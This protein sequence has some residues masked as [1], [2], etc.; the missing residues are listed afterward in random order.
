MEALIQI[1]EVIMIKRNILVVFMVFVL[2]AAGCG[3]SGG[4]G[5]GD[6]PPGETTFKV[7]GTVSGLA[8]TL[9][10]S[11][12]G[13]DD[14]T[15]TQNGAFT[16]ATA[17]ANGSP[18][19]V[20]IKTEP[21]GQICSVANGTGTVSGANVTNVSA[22]CYDPGD[23]NLYT[24][25]GTV[26]GLSGTLV[27]SNNG[28]DNLTVAQDGA[29][30]FETAIA[31]GGSYSVM[32]KTQPTGQTCSVEN[33]T[34]LITGAN[35]TN[36]TAA[37]YVPVITSIS[38]S[39]AKIGEQIQLTGT[40]F[41][42]TQGPSSVSIGGV[43][44]SS[45]AAWSDTVIT[46]TVP[47]GATTGSVV[48]TEGGVASNA[49]SL[50]V[51]WTKENPDNVAIAATANRED[52][53][54]IT[55]DGSGGALIAWQD[56]RSGTGDLYAQR[57]NSSGVAQWAAD[58][59]AIS[60]AVSSQDFPQLIA[61]GSGGAFITWQD[62]RSGTGND[63]YVQRVD[64]SGTVRWR[65]DGVAICTAADQQW[66][67][68]LVSDGSGGAIITWYDNRNGN[69]D[70][71]AQ[72]VNSTGEVQWTA[73]GVSIS[74]ETNLQMYPQLIADGSGG[75]IITW[76]DYRSGNGDI[77]A[78]REDSSGTV[79]WTADGVAISLVSVDQSSPRLVSDGSGGA[80]ITW[81]DDRSGNDDIY[82]QRVNSSGSVQWTTDGVVISAFT[83]Y[84]I[85]DDI[86]SDGSGGAIIA[87]Y[88]GRNGSDDIYIQRVNGSGVAQWTVDGVAI[89]T[90]SG[91]QNC[92][93]LIADGSGGV[94]LAWSDY[95][96]GVDND[97]YVQRVN[98][99]GEVQW[100]ADGA[101]I[102]TVTGNQTT[103]DIVSDG[104]GGAIIT[105]YDY[106]NGNFD[107]Y[108]QGVSASGRQ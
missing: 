55:S 107:I 8:G 38:P 25:G 94:I 79:R 59:V 103:P 36:V 43:P 73:D 53:P 82:A 7:G 96:N 85:I 76:Y 81:Y 32:V 75:A 93:C 1:L 11:N 26:S 40:G 64:S 88:D 67:P 39:E 60:A 19:A 46:A 56:F 12:N 50:V 13:T 18:Y 35:V 86:I 102:S 24:I 104:S 99:S 57:V 34:G 22:A 37:C 92:S 87:W 69:Y 41:G 27:L 5:G 95:R 30:T 58:G 52:S 101:A 14:A 62:F 20:T 71:Y 83:S 4:S 77:Y 70:I 10:L 74:T 63:I 80:I 97:I 51:L 105:W 108:A 47:E 78:Q 61:D 33:G 66:S 31:N 91:D 28:T 98:S 42:S 17:V 100:T 106:R 54:Q 68:R 3:G 65:A 45:I 9:V 90:V 48:V 21:S 23:T 2:A 29:F 44:A 72:R 6:L 16:F 49:V 89:S 15:I 84:Q